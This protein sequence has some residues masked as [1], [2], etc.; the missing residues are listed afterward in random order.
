MLWLSIYKTPTANGPIIII[1]TRRGHGAQPLRFYFGAIISV[2]FS[3]TAT[4]RTI[5][6]LDHAKTAA[7]QAAPVPL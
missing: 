6:R 1:F 3:P 2:E 5:S 4:E 7:I